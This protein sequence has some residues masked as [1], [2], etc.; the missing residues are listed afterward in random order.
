[1]NHYELKQNSPISEEKI[2]GLIPIIKDH[3]KRGTIDYNTSMSIQSFLINRIIMNR[4]SK[5]FA[6][7]SINMNQYLGKLSKE[8][9]IKL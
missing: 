1:M 7:F 3:E 5:S 4:L 9:F 8:I 2:R 6:S